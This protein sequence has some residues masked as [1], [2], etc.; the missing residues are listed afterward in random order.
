MGGF[1]TSFFAFPLN[2]I[3]LAGWIL[4]CSLLWSH[5]RK[6][7]IVRFFLSAT[8]TILSVSAFLVV[9]LVIGFT[10]N[11]DIASS[12]VFVCIMLLL[13]TVLLF[14]IMR[15]W[16][17]QTATGARLGAIRW[18]FLLLHLG[19]LVALGSSF[20]GAS[21][22]QTLRMKA[23]ADTP[24]REAYHM[25]GKQEWLS[26]DIVLKDFDQASYEAL[27]EVDGEAAKIGVN[28][29]YSRT[30]C[31]D[32]YLMGYDESG[33]VLEIVREPWKY[34]VIVGVAMLLAGAL[35]LFIRGP[36]RQRHIND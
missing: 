18:R 3:L 14:V 6:S 29:P 21:D 1:P 27:A 36:Q 10:G 11:R 20:W 8:G 2:L 31:E 34:G 28:H 12:W 22:V 35:L 24:I 30:L 33:C 23:L 17:E 32:V 16:R 15:G 13:Q 9:C 19:M 5:C 26:Y 25:D 7:L 4:G